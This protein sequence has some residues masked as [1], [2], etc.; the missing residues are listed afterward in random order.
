MKIECFNDFVTNL[1][2]VGFSLGGSNDEG[3]FSLSNF[4]GEN[5]CSHT[6]IADTDPWEWR[7]RVLEERN[8]IA[9]SKL[10]WSKSGWITRDWYPYFIAARRG[11]TNLCDDYMSGNISVQAK[12][13]YEIISE[14]GSAPF[15]IIKKQ[16]GFT[17]ENHSAFE[18]ALTELQRK[19]YIT[20]CGRQQ[21][22][23]KDG[24]LYGWS[25]TV[26]CTTEHFWGEA[27]FEEAAKVDKST[28]IEKLTTQ[29]YHLN[30]DAKANK[31]A[32]F[33]AG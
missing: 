8:D 9:Y 4:F 15:D 18:R 10:F 7:M 20:M 26:F 22:V 1:L 29:I 12:Q 6:G 2:E 5:I 13:I 24:K 3:I 16:G 23:S 11:R 19:M 31:V 32:K 27:I 33:I 28:A 17:K 14:T 25:S 21:K 30:P